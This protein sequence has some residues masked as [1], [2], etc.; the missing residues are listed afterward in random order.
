M[1][2][3]VSNI[4]KNT[5]YYTLAL[6]I[7]KVISFS[8]FVI[9]ARA[10]GPEDLGKYYF[11]ISF[12]TIAAIFIDVGLTNVL[13]RETAKNQDD[14][15]KLINNS[16]SIKLPLSLIT[17]LA[18]VSA[19]NLLGYPDLTK[20]LVY[21]SSLSMIL[22]SFT[23]SFF[24]VSRG[25][26]NLSFE[27]IASVLFQAIVLGVGLVTLKFGLGARALMAGL[28]S[29]SLFN[30]VYSAV[31][32]AKKWRIKLRPAFD[33]KLM[34]TILAFALPFAIFGVFQRFYTYFDS[35]LLS[36][37]SGDRE[38]GIYQVAFKVIFALQFLP[39]AFS[40]SLYPAM[41]TYWANNRAQLAVTFERAVNYLVIISLPIVIGVIAIADKVV[42]LFNSGY[43]DA[44]LPLKI[45]ILSL[46]F[47]FPTFAL[48]ALLSACD[49]QKRIMVNQG[50]VAAL[51]VILNLI[52]IPR[53][54]ATGASL[55]VAATNFL[56]FALCFVP[57][58]KIIS[59]NY[60]RMLK[61]LARVALAAAVMGLAAYYLK[62]YINVFIVVGISGLL[63]FTLLFLLGGF[64]K[65]D[66]VSIIESFKKKG[67]EEQIAAKEI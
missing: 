65:E 63:Y 36:M 1:P 37:L 67:A 61:M 21:L 14:A 19:I 33:F 47:I 12:T 50:V 57:I 9:I 52:L 53:L 26:H 48:G 5:S 11:A 44:V 54:A 24:A 31:I 30:C 6:I 60:S 45:N 23:L 13:I 28:A 25:F 16:L 10:L 55:T 2:E 41:S 7:Q 18:V 32:L 49:R 39:A 22:D 29:A 62:S 43:D 42:V 3:K 59:V 46:A 17:L 38:V 66:I 8:Y 35:V 27:S 15:A 4:A 56:M 40:A 20:H 51:S 34:K 64:H 58:P